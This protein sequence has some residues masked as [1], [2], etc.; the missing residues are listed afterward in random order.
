M[1]CW[2]GFSIGQELIPA[3]IINTDWETIKKPI[4]RM[5]YACV[6]DERFHRELT[7][8]TDV[9]EIAQFSSHSAIGFFFSP[10]EREHTLMST[11]LP[12]LLVGPGKES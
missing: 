9:I 10:L 8:N 3:L 6:A 5:R 4:V 1:A 12:F 11:W 2:P 7:E